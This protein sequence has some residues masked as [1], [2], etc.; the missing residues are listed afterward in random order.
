MSQTRIS[1]RGLK[2]INVIGGSRIFL[3][4]NYTEKITIKK[5]YNKEQ[6]RLF[7]K[8]PC[9]NVVAKHYF[10]QRRTDQVSQSYAQF[11]FSFRFS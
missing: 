1:V 10:C 9:L 5:V 4:V 11:P 3:R 7:S 2:S 8:L 6:L